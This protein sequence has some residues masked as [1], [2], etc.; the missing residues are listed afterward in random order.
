MR[1]GLRSI[2][3]GAAIVMF[4]LALL[5]EDNTL[6]L[7]LVGLMLFAGAFLAEDVA[8]TGRGGRVTTTDRI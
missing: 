6:D 1:L 7:M 2:L 5:L 8:T 3:L 4:L